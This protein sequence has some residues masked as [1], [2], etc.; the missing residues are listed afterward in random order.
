ML[1]IKNGE[2]TKS[3]LNPSETKVGFPP[4]IAKPKKDVTRMISHTSASRLAIPKRVDPKLV[5]ALSGPKNKKV[6]PI[7]AGKLKARVRDIKKVI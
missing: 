3:A 5:R 7:T 4:L 1:P 6:N 2:D